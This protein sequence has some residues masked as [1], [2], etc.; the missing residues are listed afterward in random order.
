MGV[1]GRVLIKPFR[2]FYR[3][4]DLVCLVFGN[5]FHL[6]P[7]HTI[8]YPRL[9]ESTMVRVSYPTKH[10]LEKFCIIS[11]V[12]RGGRVGDGGR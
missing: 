10:T 3:P 4:D 9:V 12:H 11:V 1:F 6:I 7:Y 2:V 8:P 5:E